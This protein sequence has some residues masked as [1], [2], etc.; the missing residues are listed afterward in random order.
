MIEDL[1]KQLSVCEA[2]RVACMKTGNETQAAW[3][4]CRITE[5][6]AQIAAITNEDESHAPTDT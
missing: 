2:Q 3:Y 6:Q 1:Q 5:L 4:K